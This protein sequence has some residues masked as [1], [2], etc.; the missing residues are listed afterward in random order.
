MARVA[1]VIVLSP[2]ERGARPQGP[3][4]AF[5]LS[6]DRGTNE[7]A[8]A[9]GELRALHQGAQVIS[10]RPDGNEPDVLFLSEAARFEPGRPV[11]GGVP[12]CFP[13]F[14][15]SREN[16]AWPQ[17][18]YARLREWRVE[19]ARADAHQARVVFF[20]P[21][22]AGAAFGA[23]P[24]E[25]RF[26]V[27]ARAAASR[28]P[29]SLALTLAVRNVGAERVAYEAALHT[30]LRVSDVAAA[31][32]RGLSGA[33][34]LDKTEA[35]RQRRETAGALALT[36]ETDRVYQ[37]HTGDCALDDPGYGRTLVV[38]KQGSLSTVVWNPWETK[39]AAIPDLAPGEW[40]RFL[41]VETANV[42]EER[43]R[44]DPGATHR[45]RVALTSRPLED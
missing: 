22:S 28:S 14:G 12:I 2:R 39:A 1:E 32:V 13:W 36:A 20:L 38:A 10:W 31:R 29:A 21:P 24:L 9:G 45:M 40:R 5:P 11:R 27:V 26:E 7:G 3:G 16:P 35:M 4:G 6:A 15:P 19:S 25:A 44:L 34:Y 33:A 43:V 30:Y 37:G 18:G 41:C 42:G 8:G 17:H 23:P